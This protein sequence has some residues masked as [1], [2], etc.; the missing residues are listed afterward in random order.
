MVV[1]VQVP[2]GAH[3]ESWNEKRVNKIMNTLPNG[4]RVSKMT[5]FPAN[6]KQKGASV[7]EKWY[8]R[9]RF[10]DGQGNVKQCY[11]GDVN[12]LTTAAERKQLMQQLIDQEMAMLMA[13][14]NPIKKDY[15]KDESNDFGSW[16]RSIDKT[17]GELNLAETTKMDMLF[18]ISKIKE[19]ANRLGFSE[20]PVNDIKRKHIKLMLK[21]VDASAYGF[22]KMRAYLMMIY[23]ELAEMDA[24]EYNYVKD[25]GKQKV[26]RKVRVMLTEKQRQKIDQH[27]RQNHYTFWRYLHIFF[28]SGAR[29]TELLALRRKDVDLA[30]QRFKTLVKKGKEYREVWRTI[31]DSALPLWKELLN[32]PGDII[33][34]WGLK[35]GDKPLH[36]DAITKNWRK[37]VKL[38]LEIEADF[39]SIKHLHTTQ[40]VDMMDEDTA[41][42]VNAHTSTAMVRGIYD[43][44][45]EKRDHE[46]VKGLKNKFA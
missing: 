20:M 21:S 37:Y 23:K 1:R 2:P 7:T 24:V 44:G 26:T 28:H 17:M 25:I 40:V 9:Y 34:S 4:C 22:N 8:C 3:F 39:Y 45:K 10:Y 18:R 43:Q 13:G 6:W 27:L 5:V 42:M 36:F 46:R 15:Q 14:F 12:R 11:L 31:K 30:G 33:F 32:E 35:P 29:S 16:I 41:A 38:P 19:A